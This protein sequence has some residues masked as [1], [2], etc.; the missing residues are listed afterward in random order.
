MQVVLLVQLEISRH[1]SINEVATRNLT[2][3]SCKIMV[4]I[5]RRNSFVVTLVPQFARIDHHFF[6]DFIFH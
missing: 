2:N 5:R 6:L 3:V 1:G 4:D